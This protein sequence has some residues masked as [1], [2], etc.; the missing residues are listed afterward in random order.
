MDVAVTPF[1]EVIVELLGVEHEVIDPGDVEKAE[2]G[3]VLVPRDLWTGDHSDYRADYAVPVSA[4][5]FSSLVAS[6]VRVGKLLS[7]EDGVI[8]RAV[9]EVL[10]VWN[11]E[12]VGFGCLWSDKK[13]IR[14]LALDLGLRLEKGCPTVKPDYEGGRVPSHGFGEA[15]EALRIRAQSLS[16][17]A[18]KTSRR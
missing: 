10:G 18:R 9:R 7:V 2:A 14:S 3:L 1:Y 12:D 13:F 15:L 5:S 16:S 8:L 6:C 17:L 4:A 11:V